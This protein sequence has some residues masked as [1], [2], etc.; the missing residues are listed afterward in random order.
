MSL[1]KRVISG[2]KE[3]RQRVIEGKVN[4]I[5]VPFP[6]FRKE[7]P[8]IQQKTY[9]LVSGAAKAGK[10]QI[11][12]YL[13]VYNTLLYAYNN[14]GKITPR[15]FYYNLEEDE[16]DITLRF[17]SFLL[18]T[19][20]GKEVSPVELSSIDERKP[21]SKD[22]IDILESEEYKDI[23]K[24]YEDHVKFMSSRNP[25]GVWKDMV[26]YANSHGRTIYEDYE[27]IDDFG[28]KQVGKKISN[29]IPDDPD[30]YVIII[31]D[32]VSLLE[33]E[34]GGT[35]KASIDKLSEYYIILR[36]RY[37]YIPV[38]VQQ[39]NIESIGIEA[40]K[41]DKIRPT[42]AGLADSKNPGK[43]CT[44]M[45]GI[46]NPY[47]AGKE[48]SLGY[49]IKKFK[50]S[51][52]CLEVVLNRKGQSNSICP[53]YFKGSVNYYKE[54]PLPEDTEEMTK[55]YNFLKKPSVIMMLFTKLN[56]YLKK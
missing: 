34:R 48:T 15:I 21:L 11:T 40:F 26:N 9:Y 3:A 6:R 16:E 46:T 4:C 1:V 50:G 29:Y 43:D 47:G 38:A 42:L 18:Y 8:G 53:L 32:H 14:P 25:T 52:R 20:S 10:T 54:L 33:T 37:R 41:V 30:E 36:N 22:I 35:L 45:L 28:K 51:F 19:L 31:T 23:L 2:I 27:Y 49:D 24:Y 13:F 55:V 5:P 12:N 39:Q 44:V 7:F 56:N 17:M